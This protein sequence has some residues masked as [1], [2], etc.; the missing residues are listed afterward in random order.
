MQFSQPTEDSFPSGLEVQTLAILELLLLYLV[1]GL[2]L[3]ELPHELGVVPVYLLHLLQVRLP[4]HSV[5]EQAVSPLLNSC[6]F[7]LLLFDGIELLLIQNPIT[8]GSGNSLY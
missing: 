8:F 7:L 3:F 5:D 6:P 4:F 1:E 2:S